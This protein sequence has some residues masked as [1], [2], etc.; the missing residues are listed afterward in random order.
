[1]K[2]IKKLIAICVAVIALISILAVTAF[3]A[4]STEEVSVRIEGV[5]SNLY[6]N[7]SFSVSFND[8]LTLGDVIDSLKEDYNAPVIKTDS[9]RRAYI[10]EIDG[11][12]IDSYD[13]HASW[14]C[15]VNGRIVTDNVAS[16]RVTAGDDI[17]IYVYDYFTGMVIPSIDTSEMML[18]YTIKFTDQDGSAI[19]GAY[20]TWDDMDYVTDQN[21]SIIVDSTGMGIEHTVQIDMYHENGLPAILRYAPDY[22]ITPTFSDVPADAWFSESVM[23]V[24]N[25]GLFQGD[26]ATT[27]SPSTDMNRAMFVT[28]LGRLAGAIVDNDAYVDFN[29][30]H[31]DNWSTGY[32][33]W[34]AENGY[35]SGYDDGSFRQYTIITREQIAAILY[36]YAEN[37]G[38][39]FPSEEEVLDSFPD[40]DSV[41]EYALDGMRWAVTNGIVTGNDDGELNPQ[42]AA[43]RAQ[44]ATILMRTAVL[45]ENYQDI[46]VNIPVTPIDPDDYERPGE[47]TTPDD[48]TTPD[49]DMNYDDTIDDSSEVDE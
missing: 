38:Y 25:C 47:D 19:V 2:R 18:G 48:E 34:A 36:R 23:F 42:G 28:V 17:V 46:D 39:K 37:C 31:Y 30:I 43:S 13:Y 40:L 29:D 5:N 12:S 3:A 35:I 7:D 20:V 33:S 32:I 41:S 1:M 11:I 26:S 49:D 24:V 22:T 9:D 44:V 16:H 6:F 21:G 10:T 27:F 8:T 45:I 4:G 15:A 14:G